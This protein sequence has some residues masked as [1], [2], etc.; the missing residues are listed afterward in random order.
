MHVLTEAVG[1]ME[2]DIL[3]GVDDNPVW[4]KKVASIRSI[5]SRSVMREAWICAIQGLSCANPGFMVCTTNHGLTAQSSDCACV[6]HGSG[7]SWDCS[8]A[9]YRYVHVHV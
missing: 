2:K 7:Q 1:Y 6:N 3:E 8:C 9:K 4:K 5:S